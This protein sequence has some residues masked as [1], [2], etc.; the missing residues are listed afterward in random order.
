MPKS[1]RPAMFAAAAVGLFALSGCIIVDADEHDLGT[2]WDSHPSYGTLKA[3]D[4]TADSVTVR[5]TS[6]GCTSKDFIGTDVRR[7]GEERFSVGFYREKEDYCRAN[8]PD[9]VALTWSFA[10]LGIPDGAE[11]KVCNTISN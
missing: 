4:V 7:M 2:D 9:G 5:V 3:A 6:N 10:E 8:L 11:V 1:L